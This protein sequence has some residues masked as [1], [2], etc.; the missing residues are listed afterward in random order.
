MTI[1][2]H[3]I[4]DKLSQHCPSTRRD[5]REMLWYLYVEEG[6]SIKQ[7][8]DLLQ[9]EASWTWVRHTLRKMGVTLRSRGGPHPKYPVIPSLKEEAKTLLPKELALKHNLPIG[10]VYYRLKQLTRGPSH[11]DDDTSQ[12]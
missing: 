6:L 11:E 1:R 7:I 9:G 3:R 4:I 8:A 5:L 12:E 2:A 10:T